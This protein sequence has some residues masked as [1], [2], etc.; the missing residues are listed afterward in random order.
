MAEND[1]LST[2]VLEYNERLYG[3]F[4]H[5]FSITK[6]LLEEQSSF[7]QSKLSYD[8]IDELVKSVPEEW[9]PKPKDIDALI[10]YLMYRVDNLNVITSTILNYIKK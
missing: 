1:L 4:Y 2:K 3:M 7:F 5:N 6:E 9:K 10:K 8:I